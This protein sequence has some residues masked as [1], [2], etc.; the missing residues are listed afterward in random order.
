MSQPETPDLGVTISD[1]VATVEIQRPPHNFFDISLIAQIAETYEW[2]D[3]NPECRAIVLCAQGKNFC[4]GA[5]FGAS[6]AGGAKDSSSGDLSNDLYRQAVRIFRCQTPVVAAVQGAAIGGGLG[7][8]VSADFRVT[9]PEGRF[10]ANFT[11]L[12]FHPGF[13]LTTTLP[14]LIGKQ[15][16]SLMCLTSRRI[17]GEEAAEW[18]LA[19]MCVPLEQIRDAASSLAQEIAGCAPLAVVS[20]RSTLRQGLAD[21][22]AAQTEHELSEQNAL[23]KTRDWEE[24]IAAAAERREPEFT[25]S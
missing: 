25:G 11:R 12:G 9:C 24:G 20:T 1:R 4:A 2:L 3:T 19:D 7:L 17:K 6:D 15:R 21:R 23:R 18:G 10:S 13:G 14:D 8:A 16:A 5:N 22:V